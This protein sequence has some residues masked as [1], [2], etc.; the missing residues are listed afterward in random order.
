MSSKVY[1]DAFLVH[2]TLLCS[3]RDVL[4]CDVSTAQKNFAYSAFLVPDKTTYTVELL[5]RTRL[6]A[7]TKFTV[8]LINNPAEAAH[9]VHL[10]KFPC[11]FA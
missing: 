1:L 9:Y 10:S 7:E 8:T 11:C 5:T 3:R 4:C 6:T 2:F